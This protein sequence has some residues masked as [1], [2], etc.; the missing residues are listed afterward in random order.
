MVCLDAE[1]ALS[2]LERVKQNIITNDTD[3]NYSRVETDLQLLTSL[4]KSPVLKNILKVEDSLGDLQS[5]LIHHPSLLP[6]DFDINNAGHLVLNSNVLQPSQPGQ[7]KDVNGK[8]SPPSG[9][10]PKNLPA[11][12]QNVE[13]VEIVDNPTLQQNLLQAAA[14]RDIIS[15]QVRCSSI[16]TS[17]FVFIRGRILHSSSKFF[18]DIMS[19]MCLISLVE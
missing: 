18:C 7:E 11:A 17:A 12:S 9:Q 1:R 16:T 10:S 4:L 5:H 15:I 2:L 3:N 19:R 14:K 8:L 6:S 13:T